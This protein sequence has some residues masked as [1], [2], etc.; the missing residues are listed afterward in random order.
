MSLV[1]GELSGAE[2]S[3]V[4]R[5]IERPSRRAAYH[6]LRQV[7]AMTW[8]EPRPGKGA[9]CAVFRDNRERTSVHI[10]R[11]GCSRPLAGLAD[12]P[13]A[14]SPDLD[15]DGHGTVQNFNRWMDGWAI[16]YSHCETRVW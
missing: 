4:G 3:D 14:T 15:D 6:R 7:L 11:F 13:G 2:T 9:A 16:P 5:R 1:T 10:P 12:R 8:Y